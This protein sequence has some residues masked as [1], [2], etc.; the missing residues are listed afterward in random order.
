MWLCSSPLRL[1]FASQRPS[2]AVCFLCWPCLCSLHA[3]SPNSMPVLAGNRREGQGGAGEGSWETSGWV[4]QWVNSMVSRQ[5]AGASAAALPR[6][7]GACS[8]CG[9]R[10]CNTCGCGLPAMLKACCLLPYRFMRCTRRR[11]HGAAR[12]AQH[13]QHAQRARVLHF[14]RCTRRRSRRYSRSPVVCRNSRPLRTRFSLKPTL[15]EGGGARRLIQTSLYS[16]AVRRQ[17]GMRGCVEAHS[18]G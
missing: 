16:D 7:L 3:P 18:A 11:P 14:M 17:G 12:C 1:P 9:A 5:V 10:P 6:L 13:A 2:F 15:H 4:V 8:R